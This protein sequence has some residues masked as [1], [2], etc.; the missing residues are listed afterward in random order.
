MATKPLT[1]LEKARAARAANKAAG[2][3]PS[4]TTAPT[5]KPLPTVA[6]PADFKPHFVEVVFRTE[7][8]GLLGSDIKATRYQGRY[9][10]D[11]EDRKK[12]R[13]MLT[14]D[15]QTVIGIQARFAALV[16][17]ATNDKKYSQNPKE[18]AKQQG[19]HRL[20]PSTVFVVLVR[21]RK[22]GE[23]NIATSVKQVW[24]R[25]KSKSSGRVV[26]VELD[27]STDPAAR[28]IKRAGR[29][30]PQAF[31]NVQAPPALARRRKG[32]DESVDE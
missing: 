5:R 11:S 29:F 31:K 19:A 6:A 23:D 8:D 28:M 9:D 30:L 12:K 1:P 21:V 25:A 2:G 18:R 20:P 27:S 15:P 7:A 13:E 3:K 14:Y 22:N 32:D 4:A 17:K 10:P 24:Q 26:A 16:Y